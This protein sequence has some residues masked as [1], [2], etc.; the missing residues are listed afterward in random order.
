M[1][2]AV[3]LVN[4]NLSIETIPCVDSILL[5][6]HKAILIFLVDNGSNLTDFQKLVD[7]FKGNMRVMV[8]RIEKNRGYVGGVNYGLLKARESNPDYFLVMNNDT[9]IDQDAIGY[10][11]DSAKRHNNNA[12]VTGK[13]YYYDNP[14]I[15]QHT[16]EIITDFRFLKTIAP[17]RNEKDIGQYDVEIER[18][19]LDDVF[20]L[21]PSRVVAEVGLYCDY[22]FLYAEQGDYVLRARRKGFLLIF[23]PKA[24]IWHKVSMTSGGGDSQA[25]PI[26]YW[27]GQGMFVLQYR[28][29]KVHWFIISVV[30]NLISYSIKA[31]YSKEEDKK[32]ILAMRRGYSWGLLWMLN[33]RPNDGKNPYVIKDQ[34]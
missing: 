16:G 4:Y 8:L 25:L 11:V 19:A 32:R 13:V 27:R 6:K 20:W 31:L 9:V 29:L 26:C 12:I 24:K 22:F 28:N 3:V 14:D 34:H 7:R 30:K 1:M 10:L 15:L 2:V 23:T 33:K 18:D 5:S 21:L 17:G